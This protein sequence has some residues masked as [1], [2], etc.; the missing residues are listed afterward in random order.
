V[1]V[2]I[3]GDD[4][5]MLLKALD[6]ADKECDRMRDGLE[7]LQVDDMAVQAMQ[8]MFGELRVATK[9]AHR[10]EYDWNFQERRAAGVAL[11]FYKATINKRRDGDEKLLIDPRDIVRKLG[12]VTTLL[13]ELS[14]QETLFTKPTDWADAKPKGKDAG[15]EQL[16]IE[17]ASSA[18]LDDLIDTVADG[19][20]ADGVEVQVNRRAP[21]RLEHRPAPKKKAAKKPGRP[22][23]DD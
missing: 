23:R 16:D 20:K 1:R 13:E 15:D 6:L 3:L 17:E 22:P 7:R 21:R 5:A 8:G 2:T 12:E 9:D 18:R 4:R 19:L 14:G 10:T 11:L